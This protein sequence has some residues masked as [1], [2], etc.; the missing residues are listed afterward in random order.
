MKENLE[1]IW[2]ADDGRAQPHR[3]VVFRVLYGMTG[4]VGRHAHRRD[5]GGVVDIF[6]Q[7][8]AV[9][10]GIVVIR[11]VA[12]AGPDGHIIDAVGPQHR[13]RRLRA[14]ETPP[15]GN[16]AVPLEVSADLRLRPQGQQEHRDQQ[17]A[18]NIIR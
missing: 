14:G 11:Q 1:P 18:V 17:N 2:V 3:A 6:R 15:V 5:G 9:V 7:G 16:T 13:L 10:P 12:G 8:N 4:L